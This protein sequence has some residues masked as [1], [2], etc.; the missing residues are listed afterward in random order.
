MLKQIAGQTKNM[1]ANLIE[2]H[3]TY[4]LEQHSIKL[5]W[6]DAASASK[7]VSL[8]SKKTAA[9]KD[10]EAYVLPALSHVE[11]QAPKAKGAGTPMVSWRR[12]SNMLPTFCNF[13]WGNALTIDVNTTTHHCPPPPPA[14]SLIIIFC[15]LSLSHSNV[16][17]VF[18]NVEK[19]K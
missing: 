7:G 19:L 17:L 3:P 12:K 14:S 6:K 11:A 5:I 10:G 4:Q 8:H 9:K 2:L 15:V 16:Y 13:F 1:Y 18:P